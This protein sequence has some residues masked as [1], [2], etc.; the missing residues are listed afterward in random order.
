MCFL[1]PTHRLTDVLIISPKLVRGACYQK[2]LRLSG[3]TCNTK[4]FR[5]PKKQTNKMI[6]FYLR[7]FNIH[8]RYIFNILLS[9]WRLFINLALSLKFLLVTKPWQ[10]DEPFGLT[11]QYALFAL[12]H[13][14]CVAGYQGPAQDITKLK[15]Y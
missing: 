10:I 4:P 14:Q 2:R 12:L 6:I 13:P 3:T 7:A 9:F 8:L 5:L 11:H 1:K 15:R